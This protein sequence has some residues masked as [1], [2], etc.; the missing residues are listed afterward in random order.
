MQIECPPQNAATYGCEILLT[1]SD[2]QQA[3]KN[4]TTGNTGRRLQN[5]WDQHMAGIDRK[6]FVDCS[7]GKLTAFP[8]ISVP[9]PILC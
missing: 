5:E 1:G 7:T 8:N 9:L 3:Y 6:L 4:M 2:V